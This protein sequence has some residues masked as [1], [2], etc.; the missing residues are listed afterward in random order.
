MTILSIIYDHFLL[1][2]IALVCSI[3]ATMLV[4]RLRSPRVLDTTPRLRSLSTFVRRRRA[5][6]WTVPILVWG[7]ESISQ[8]IGHLDRDTSTVLDSAAGGFGVL[9]SFLVLCLLLG[10]LAWLAHVHRRHD[11]SWAATFVRP[12]VIAT[13]AGVTSL[14]L[15]I[16]G[17]AAAVG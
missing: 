12:P 2:L 5:T 3:A 7:F 10:C 6:L 8:L 1:T 17:V 9:R 4:V 11:P 14:Q 16:L 13:L 15:I